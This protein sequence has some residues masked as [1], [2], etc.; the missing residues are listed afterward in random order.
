MNRGGGDY[1]QAHA[2]VAASELNPPPA[3][4]SYSDRMGN[5]RAAP[6][7]NLHLTSKPVAMPG[8]MFYKSLSEGVGS[9][10]SWANYGDPGKDHNDSYNYIL[11]N[12]PRRDTGT[13][14]AVLPGGGAIM[15]NIGPNTHVYA[16]DV[17]QQVLDSYSYQTN[18]ING[19]TR[20]AYVHLTNPDGENLW[21]WFLVSYKF[22]IRDEPEVGLYNWGS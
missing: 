18:T 17:S 1:S 20:W 10:S 12:M 21:G 4:L 3:L 8:D 16:C 9:G 15:A 7:C 14:E 5:G 13:G 22:G 11:W 2:H 6:G 19:Y